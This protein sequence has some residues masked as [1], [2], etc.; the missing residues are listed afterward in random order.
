[1]PDFHQRVFAAACE[2][3]PIRTQCKGT[4]QSYMPSKNTASLEMRLLFCSNSVFLAPNLYCAA[5]I[6]YQYGQ[7]IV[8][9]SCNR[10]ITISE[11]S[12]ISISYPPTLIRCISKIM[13]M[14]QVK[15]ALTIYNRWYNQHH[16][17]FITRSYYFCVGI[18]IKD[19][20][21]AIACAGLRAATC[22][23]NHGPCSSDKEELP[24]SSEARRN[25]SCIFIIIVWHH[26]Q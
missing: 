18:A 24:I 20:Q 14:I 12:Y 13:S 22:Y 8:A 25:D 23:A 9:Y 17:L 11:R 19:I 3:L 10:L 2:C 5:V 6:S 15:I 7:R 16:L 26:S 21:M 1:M 4:D